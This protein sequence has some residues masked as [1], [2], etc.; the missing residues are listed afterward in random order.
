MEK[1]K[2]R[3]SEEDLELAKKVNLQRYFGAKEKDGWSFYET[4]AGTGHWLAYH[5]DS[6]KTINTIDAVMQIE[7]KSFVDAVKSLLSFTPAP[8]PAY[9][10]ELD[11]CLAN[12]VDVDPE[13]EFERLMSLPKDEWAQ[14]VAA[15]FKAQRARAEMQAE[16][17]EWDKND[18]TA[19]WL[20]IGGNSADIQKA[21]AL[22][23]LGAQSINHALRMDER[24]IAV[25]LVRAAEIPE[26]SPEALDNALR[27]QWA[28]MGKV[29]KKVSNTIP[30]LS[31]KCE[32]AY[33]VICETYEKLNPREPVVSVE[34]V[35]VFDFSKQDDLQDVLNPKDCLSS[36]PSSTKTPSV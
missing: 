26:L 18:V 12:V 32:G 2:K 11:R 27:Q 28:M 21:E 36:S 31:E 5:K 10:D 1:E 29:M 30:E 9:G 8:A 16:M 24:D 6:K 25:A 20:R 13:A 19:E 15:R 22:E 3:F 23:I 7:K 14:E 34:P 17:R 33:F 35:P 4:K